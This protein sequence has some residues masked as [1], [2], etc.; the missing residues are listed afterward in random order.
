MES[1][2][3]P[4]PS[5]DPYE[6]SRTTP[7]KYMSVKQVAERW[8]INTMAVYRQVACGRLPALHLGQTIRIPIADVLRFEAENT[9]GRQDH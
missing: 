4:D 6:T 5:D 2:L 9:S 1:P 8:N 7:T 3:K